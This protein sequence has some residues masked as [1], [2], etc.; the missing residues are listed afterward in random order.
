MSTIIAFE[1]PA[2]A[3][4][5]GSAL[6]ADPGVRV[7]IERVVPVS[8]RVIPY[9]WVTGDDDTGIEA[10]LDADPDV[11]SFETV[12][13]VDDEVLVRVTWRS[14]LDGFFDVLVE[15]GGVILDAVGEAG[16]WSMTVQFDDRDGLGRFYR[17]CA[18]RGVPIEVLRVHDLVP[19]GETATELGL[20]D[21]QYRT[22]R[23]AFEWGYFAVPRRTSLSDL[24]AE[25]GVS[26][27][28]VSQRLRRGT[29]AVLETAFGGEVDGS[30][31]PVAPGSPE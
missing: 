12:E 20:T 10:A 14:G 29:S 17:T 2:E 15:S 6:A 13:R 11:E 30:D 21:T 22:L 16:R 25:F 3:F 24:A 7:R 4:V 26:D 9:L 23:T 8:E 28:A 19:P 5:L 1:V 27:T 18:D 31:A